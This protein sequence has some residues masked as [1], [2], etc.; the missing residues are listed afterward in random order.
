R[1]G[2]DP[3]RK[4]WIHGNTEP[5]WGLIQTGP[6]EL[7][8]YW[9]ETAGQVGSIAQLRRGTLRLDGFV[10][11]HAGYKGGEFVTKPLVFKGKRL[12]INFSTSAVGSVSVEIQDATGKPLPGFSLAQSALIY[13]D[14]IERAVV[15][16][17]S[18]DLGKL[19]GKPVRL[20][21]V[22]KDA[23]VYSLRFGTE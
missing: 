22:M 2:L 21:F 13:G 9:I 10:S 17:D 20:R 5:A 8:V 3:Q 4:S 7:S 1:P 23:D 19:A 18:A 6:T 14:S 15:W 11:M 16:K 12:A